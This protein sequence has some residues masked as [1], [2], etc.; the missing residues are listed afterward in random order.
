MNFKAG[1]TRETY[2]KEKYENISVTR[3]N[4]TMRSSFL[5]HPVDADV[6]GIA[7]QLSQSCQLLLLLPAFPSQVPSPQWVL[8]YY[9]SGCSLYILLYAYKGRL[10]ILTKCSMN[11]HQFLQG[12]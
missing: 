11:I 5:V 7:L 4:P 6:G 1:F 10:R 2:L 3:I 9:T 12:A 8:N